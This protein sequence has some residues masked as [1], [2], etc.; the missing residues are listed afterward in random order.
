[1]ISQHPTVLNIIV[2]SYERDQWYQRDK[3]QLPQH[4]FKHDITV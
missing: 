2:W 4:T 3:D 1:M